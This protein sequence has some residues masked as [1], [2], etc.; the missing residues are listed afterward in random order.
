MTLKAIAL[1]RIP[2]LA[3]PPDS[4]LAIEVLED[5]VLVDTGADFASEPAALTIHLYGALGPQL[6]TD[7]ED[8]RGIFYLP[9]VAKPKARTY[10]G[11]IEEI[12]E[13]GMWGPL[14][15]AL[16]ADGG[17]GFEGLFGQLLGQLPS[18]LLGAATAAA[19]GDASA[20]QAMTRD[21]QSLMGSSPEF[22][23]MAAQL[24]GMLGQPGSPFANLPRDPAELARMA[25]Q[26]FG[27][28][29]EAE[30]DEAEDSDTSEH[31]KP[32]K[33]R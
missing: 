7:H 29:G 12:G 33:S 26:F 24:A 16:E 11:V 13:G 5:A 19:Q 2:Q 14:P 28:A 8:P 9:H 20:L 22:R 3:A 4:G 1:L 27:Q 17:G 21:V 23:G 10:E 31:E 32:K 6:E 30:E 15:T 18:S 25:E